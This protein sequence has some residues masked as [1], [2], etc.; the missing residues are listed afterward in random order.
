MNRAQTVV[1]PPCLIEGFP[2]LDSAFAQARFQ[3]IMSLS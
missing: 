2:D 1:K 3:V